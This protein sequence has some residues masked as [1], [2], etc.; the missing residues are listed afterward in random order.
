MTA[1]PPRSL[2]ARGAEFGRDGRPRP[3]RRNEHGGDQRQVDGDED[4][5]ATSLTK[6]GLETRATVGRAWA[7]MALHEALR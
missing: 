7:W 5:A 2:A 3:G 1:S 4:Q 6:L